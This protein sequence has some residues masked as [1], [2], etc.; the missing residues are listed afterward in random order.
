MILRLFTM[1]GMTMLLA[2]GFVC[3]LEHFNPAPPPLMVDAGLVH[4]AQLL[5]FCVPLRPRMSP[6]PRR[7]LPK[8]VA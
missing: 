5:Q 2:L 6:P 7:V 3:A 1:F 4:P 8:E